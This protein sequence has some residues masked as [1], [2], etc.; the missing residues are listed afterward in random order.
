MVLMSKIYIYIS[1]LRS[2]WEAPSLSMQCLK[3][4]SAGGYTVADDYANP[5]A[6]EMERREWQGAQ[7]AQDGILCSGVNHLA[8]CFV[9]ENYNGTKLRGRGLTNLNT[10][11]SIFR[12]ALAH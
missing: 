1:A 4:T 9:S 10:M 6:S 7:R 12:I 11:K 3:Q 5:A 8:C 2:S